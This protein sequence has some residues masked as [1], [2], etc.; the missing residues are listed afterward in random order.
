MLALGDHWASF[1]YD[2]R[3]GETTIPTEQDAT[4]EAASFYRSL[5]QALPTEAAIERPTAESIEAIA[6]QFSY[7]PEI[8]QDELIRFVYKQQDVS[9]SFAGREE[10]PIYPT[11]DQS[12]PAYLG[13]GS[14]WINSPEAS[15]V[16]SI[17]E[18][19]KA[20]DVKNGISAER[21]AEMEREKV[22]QWQSERDRLSGYDA[23]L[24]EKREVNK[25]KPEH[26]VVEQSA[27]GVYMLLAKLH[28]EDNHWGEQ[29]EAINNSHYN[30]EAL[31]LIDAI[32]AV[33]ALHD[34][35]DE[36]AKENPPLGEVVVISWLQGDIAAKQIVEQ[37][38]KE[39]NQYEFDAQE[40]ARANTM[41]NSEQIGDI[42]PFSPSDLAVVHATSHAP[43]KTS[44]GYQ[45]ITT[46]D[47][48]G[49][50][51]ASIHTSLNYQVESHNWGQWD[52]SDYVVI[53]E[54]DD[55]L[56]ANGSPKS[57]NGR[58]TWWTR[59]PGEPLAF[60]GAT[61][62]APG[63][64]Q[65]R[66]ADTSEDGEIRYKSQNITEEDIQATADFYHSTAPEAIRAALQGK[67]G[68][69][70]PL[71]SEQGQHIVANLLR[72]F[73]ARQELVNKRGKKLYEQADDKFMD[74]EMSK[75]L[76]KMA[77]ELQLPLASSLHAES[78]ESSV[79]HSAQMRKTR[80]EDP[81][82]RRI[83]YAS[84][85]MSAGGSARQETL[86]YEDEELPSL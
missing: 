75:K 7:T 38:V 66:L 65:E 82:V 79:E 73:T 41:H 11:L 25:D 40:K 28:P 60:P 27:L 31:E 55:M 21:L 43:I 13:R 16:P 74:T 83:A 4:D 61:L 57:I 76:D 17:P 72:D 53:S 44:E 5:E 64:A 67:D 22:E 59:N 18:Q 32:T 8:D 58:D 23:K 68:Q 56:Q 1:W 39:Q 15:E 42:E 30:A 48:T 26:F 19:V 10:T 2:R 34:N 37:A 85:F 45:A 46:F 9:F 84:G 86:K 14:W 70:I 62:I 52:S 6:A 69:V 3:M 54:L 71:E 51:R 77:G 81:K 63:G 20:E 36:E 80:F 78:E 33:N 49:F 35:L 24:A 47:A 29:I 12:R 50:P